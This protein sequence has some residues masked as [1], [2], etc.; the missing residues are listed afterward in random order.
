V[1]DDQL[2]QS[3]EGEDVD[4]HL[5]AGLGQRDLFQGPVGAV[6][7]VVHHDVDPAGVADDPIDQVDHGV[8]VGEVGGHGGDAELGQVGHPVEPA[9]DRVDAVTEAMQL[10]GR[11]LADAGRGAGHQGDGSGHENLRKSNWLVGMTVI[12]ADPDVNKPVGWSTV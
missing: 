5:P 4:L 1:R 9:R 10:A 7:G 2:G 11:G 6:A 3:R 8:V 12:R